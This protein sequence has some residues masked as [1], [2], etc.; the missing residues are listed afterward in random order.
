MRSFVQTF[1]SI[2]QRTDNFINIEIEQYK[3]INAF[4]YLCDKQQLLAIN[5]IS[6]K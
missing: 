1:R 3:H 6:N 2:N 4:Y 5:Q